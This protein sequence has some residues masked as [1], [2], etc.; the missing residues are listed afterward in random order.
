MVLA[1][2][3]S[4]KRRPNDFPYYRRVWLRVVLTLLAAS[5]IPLLVIGGG[6]SSFTFDKMEE[7]AL[8]NLRMQV[9]S[10]QA[11]IDRFLAERMS[12]LKMMAAMQSRN[13]LCRPGRLQFILTSLQQQMPGFV[14]LGVIDFRGIQRA[15]AGPYDLK[16]RRYENQKLVPGDEGPKSLYQRR[17]P[18]PPQKPPFHHGRKKGKRGGRV[19]PAGNH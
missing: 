7:S 11:A 9:R 17:I 10:H 2:L 5:F 3:F 18:W 19:Y 16:G 6:V 14:D 1:N 13:E 12:Q 15:Y 8:D 4:R